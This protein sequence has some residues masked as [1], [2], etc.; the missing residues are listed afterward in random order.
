MKI[1]SMLPGSRQRHDIRANPALTNNHALANKTPES[2]RILSRYG[3]A[4]LDQ[5][6]GR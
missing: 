2:E 4:I 3:A 1:T 5:R 6:S